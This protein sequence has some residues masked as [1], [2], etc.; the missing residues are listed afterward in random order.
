MEMIE[1]HIQQ[2][3]NNNRRTNRKRTTPTPTTIALK[4]GKY[5]SWWRITFDSIF[6]LLS[7]V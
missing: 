7:L 2:T 6:R 5:I 1:W 3:G 4:R